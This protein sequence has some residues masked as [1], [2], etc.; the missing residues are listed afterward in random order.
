V[1]LYRMLKAFSRDL[2][3]VWEPR[4]DGQSLAA[5]DGRK[6]AGTVWLP[7]YSD[8]QA[9]VWLPAPTVA[10]FESPKG[11]FAASLSEAGQPHRLGTRT[12]DTLDAAI[13]KSHVRGIFGCA[14]HAA[15]APPAYPRVATVYGLVSAASAGGYGYAFGLSAAATAGLALGVLG[16][17]LGRYVL[18]VWP[19]YIATLDS[20][21]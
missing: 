7:H 11:F 9:A 14:V 16:L 12:Y 10:V 21:E 4:Y 20:G 19:W 15:E 3:H 2:R 8:G 1:K 5:K 13:Q 6:V 17:Y 18:D